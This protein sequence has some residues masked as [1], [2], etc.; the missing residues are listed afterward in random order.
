MKKLILILSS[1]LVVQVVLVITF[2]L[3]ETDYDTFQPQ[4]KLLAFTPES[5][6]SLKISDG[7]TQLPLSKH[8]D[9]WVLPEE[10]NFPVDSSAIKQLLEQ[11][12]KIGKGWPIATSNEAL[13]RFKVSDDLY[14]YRLSFSNH[15]KEIAQLYIGT[16]PGYRKV[17]ARPGND[18]RVFSIDFDSWR[19]STKADDWI[20]KNI[21]L[22]DKDE[23]AEIETSKFKLLNDNGQFKLEGIQKNEELNQ[24]KVDQ[25]V[26]TI[27]GMQIKSR[28]STKS[29]PE[30]FLDSATFEVK[31]KSKKGE[32]LVYHFSKLKDTD[33][34]LLQRSDK[35]YSYKVSDQTAKQ[36][37]DLKREQLVSAA[38]PEP[39]TKS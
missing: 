34:Y 37:F 27:S 17:H 5:I 18:D 20:D 9:G 4:E 31:V 33:Y 3:A 14:E 22:I 11:L 35:S 8:T 39:E 25:L 15:E 30:Q 13:K 32:D 19:V 7:K 6:D 38:P 23:I 36:L 16:S 12:S 10:Q 24:A 21:L 2:N 1:L 28:F 29:N 26:D